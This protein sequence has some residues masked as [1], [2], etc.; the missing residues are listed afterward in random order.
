MDRL[1]LS[2]RNA[3]KL[4]INHFGAGAILDVVAEYIGESLNHFNINQ[5]EKDRAVETILLEFSKKIKESL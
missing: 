5:K 2:E 3:I 4:Q 1:S